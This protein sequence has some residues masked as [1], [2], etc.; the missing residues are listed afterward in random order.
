MRRS[1]AGDKALIKRASR[2]LGFRAPYSELAED[3]DVILDPSL[4]P[5]ARLTV[6]ATDEYRS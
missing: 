1:W 4:I 5:T 2:P 6:P 3:R